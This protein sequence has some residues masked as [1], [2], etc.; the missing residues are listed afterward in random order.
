MFASAAGNSTLVAWDGSQT[1]NLALLS[2]AIDHALVVDD[3]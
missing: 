3:D 2:E 1:N